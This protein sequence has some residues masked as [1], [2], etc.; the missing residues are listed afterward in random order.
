MNWFTAI[1]QQWPINII[2]V[3]FYGKR[4]MAIVVKNLPTNVGDIKRFWD[5]LP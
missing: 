2:N 5:F 4:T 1:L 3:R